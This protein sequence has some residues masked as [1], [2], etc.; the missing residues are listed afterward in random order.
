MKQYWGMV[1]ALAITAAALGSSLAY[2]DRPAHRPRAVM[3]HAMGMAFPMLLRGVD[4][5]DTQKDQ[6]KEIV[7]SHRS[8]V[9]DQ[10]TQMR[11]IQSDMETKLLS[12]ENLEET[13]LTAQIQQLSQLRNQL[14]DENLKITLEIRKLLTPEQ[15]AQA[16]QSREQMQARWSEM[17]EHFRKKRAE[18]KNN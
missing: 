14:A 10:L 5:T 3:W 4:L 15:L 12:A 8:T 9:R 6:V 16:A 11:S 18:E 17:K 2:A 13:D 7:T 1:G